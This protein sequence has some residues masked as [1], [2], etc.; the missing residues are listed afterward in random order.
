[1][2][3]D[4]PQTH[5]HVGRISPAAP[6]MSANGGTMP[7]AGAHQHHYL[8]QE[9]LRQSLEAQGTLHWRHLCM[10]AGQQW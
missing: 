8:H 6:L 3:Q 1:M 4:L 2:Q 5:T 9:R 10:Y 7:D